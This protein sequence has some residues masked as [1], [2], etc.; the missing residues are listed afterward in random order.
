MQSLGRTAARLKTSMLSQR[1]A[2]HRET[3]LMGHTPRCYIVG[4]KYGRTLDMLPEMV[5]VG[6]VATGFASDVDLRRC[7]S[8]NSETVRERLDRLLPSETGTARG[9]LA[10]FLALR[11]GD[12]IA[13]KSHSAPDRSRPRLVIARY[14]VVT[15][16]KLPKYHRHPSL[17]H[18]FSVDFL[19]PQDPIEFHFGYGG[20]IHEITAQDRLDV[21]FGAYPSVSQV[22]AIKRGS[23]SKPNRATHKSVVAA[24]EPYVMQ[25]MHN[26]LQ[27]QLR[28][29][30]EQFHGSKAVAMEENFVDLAVTLPDRYILFEVKSSPSPTQ[31][32]R[33]ALGQILHYAWRNGHPQ[34]N[35]EFYVVGPLPLQPSDA[36]FLEY[37]KSR[38][39]L[40]LSYCRPN[41]YVPT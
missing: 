38:T 6:V 9:S 17:G 21:I 22:F 20:T 19:E 14:A 25:R 10:R 31:C 18:T 2:I 24:R 30:L 23:A 13:L 8:N 15:G 4:T 1:P 11:P 34:M 16:I 29:I 32:I 12:I 26:E 36:E 41:D 39:G 37:I 3:L 27:N 40:P 5:S 33:E 35:V 7:F 28:R